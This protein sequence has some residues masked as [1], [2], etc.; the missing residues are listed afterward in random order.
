MVACSVAIASNRAPLP[1][2]DGRPG[3]VGAAARDE[4]VVVVVVDGVVVVVVVVV[5]GVGC[6]EVIAAPPPGPMRPCRPPCR[7]RR[8]R[9]GARRDSRT[10]WPPIVQR[11]APTDAAPRS[12]P[13]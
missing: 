5:V 1:A 7:R 11:P 10:A 13:G 2:S 3:V 4:V 9:R 12:R 6:G 8:S